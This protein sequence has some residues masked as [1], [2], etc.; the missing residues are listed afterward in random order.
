MDQNN[1]IIVNLLNEIASLNPMLFD[2]ME[3]AFIEN[4]RWPR[5]RSCSKATSLLQV[6]AEG[7]GFE[8]RLHSEFKFDKA[9]V[10][11]LAS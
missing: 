10:G 5:R 3:K 4:L 2:C 11:E 1:I 7:E 6:V 8:I 9:A